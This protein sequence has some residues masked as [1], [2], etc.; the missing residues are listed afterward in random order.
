MHNTLLGLTVFA[1]AAVI[2]ASAHSRC[3][4][5]TAGGIPVDP[6]GRPCVSGQPLRAG[7]DVFV[8]AP[9]VVV[10]EMRPRRRIPQQ[11]PLQQ[12]SLPS[13]GFT[14]GSIGPFTTGPLSPS[15]TTPLAPA[16]FT[17]RSR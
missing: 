6:F 16:P 9:G 13:F 5:A 14:T 12:Q 8:E 1:I 3:R 4:P 10:P 11:Q 7:T 2:S 17:P 15:T